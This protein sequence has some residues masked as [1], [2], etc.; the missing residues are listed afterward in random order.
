MA[1]K[2]VN[3]ANEITYYF[4]LHCT[5]KYSTK[6]DKINKKKNYVYTKEK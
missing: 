4:S 6:F 1:K 5:I 2:Q 3:K